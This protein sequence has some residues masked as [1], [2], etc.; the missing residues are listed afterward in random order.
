MNLFH[1][2]PLE[3]IRKGQFL[4][5]TIS[6]WLSLLLVFLLFPI[7]FF[8]AKIE[9]ICFFYSLITAEYIFLLLSILWLKFISR[10]AVFVTI[11]LILLSATIIHTF[12]MVYSFGGIC[13][14]NCSSNIPQISNDLYSSIYFSIVSWT[15]LGYGDY[16]PL[17]WVRIIASLEALIGYIFMGV[18]IGFASQITYEMFKKSHS[19]KEHQDDLD[20]EMGYGPKSE[21]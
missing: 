9:N 14:A 10:R 5:A 2:N 18:V 12:S 8:F 17:G 7:A 1:T 3:E 19:T 6:N 13:Y 21:K 11:F 20:E 4:H 16:Q 15:T